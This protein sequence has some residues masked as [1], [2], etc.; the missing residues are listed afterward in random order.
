VSSEE[1]S[2]RRWDG[3]LSPKQWV[4]LTALLVIAIGVLV[5]FV[6]LG[7]FD[8][9]SAGPTATASVANNPDTHEHADFALFIRGQQFDFNQPQ[10][11]STDTHDVDPYVHIHEPRTT[12]VHVHKQGITW[13]MFFTSLGFTLNDPSFAAITP[14]QT[15][16]KLPSGETLKT[17]ATETFKFYV[18]GVKVDGVAAYGIH[19]L[20]RVLI[21]Y[22]SE[23]DAD[24]VATQLPKVT[25]QACIPSERC[26]DRIPAG[27]P[28]ETCSVSNN[29]VKP[30]G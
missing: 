10:F 12:V 16:L 15:S 1:G 14:A 19:D 2:G 25:D 26:K 17:S 24:V 20:D 9:S 3:W 11:I 18:N 27:E 30:G 22:G 4:P 21:S 13:D 23:S 29:C 6:A 5:A 7:T 28:P 8:D